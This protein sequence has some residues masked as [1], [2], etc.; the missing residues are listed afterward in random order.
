MTAVMFP[1]IVASAARAETTNV[2]GQ[3]LGATAL[4]AGAAAVLCTL[5]PTLPL[6]VVYDQSFLDVAGPLVPW[7]AWCLVPLTLANV[8][9]NN[10]LARRTFRVVPWLVTIAAGYGAALALFATSF[11]AVI[12]TLGVFSLLLFAVAAWFTWR[13]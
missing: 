7:F 1:K 9:V 3:A 10:L 13:R 4:L 2:L 8:L 6:R 12:Q 11:L 5:F